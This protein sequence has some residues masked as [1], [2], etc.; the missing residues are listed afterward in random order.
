MFGGIILSLSAG[1]FIALSMVTQRYALAYESYRVPVFCCRLP[2]P[3]VWFLGLIIYGAAN[4]LYAAAVLLA[5][6]SLVASLYT[7]L[8][9]FN[10][11]FAK[12]ILG[13]KLTPPKLVGSLLIIAGATASVLGQPGTFSGEPTPTGFS[14]DDVLELLTQPSASRTSCC[15]SRA[16]R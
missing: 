1:T 4:G 16:S 7:L 12:L 5:P 14:V 15:S 6:L 10:L 8:L 3:A 13:E 9:V 11:L 2:R